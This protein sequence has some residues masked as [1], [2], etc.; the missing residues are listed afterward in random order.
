MS[1]KSKKKKRK[2]NKK[3]RQLNIK[4]IK[5]KS[6]IEN[7]KLSFKNFTSDHYIIYPFIEFFL[8]MS[9][10]YGTFGIIYFHFL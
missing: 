4:P 8:Y 9:L 7:L 1:K 3:K 2:I 6:Y 10:I 5:Q